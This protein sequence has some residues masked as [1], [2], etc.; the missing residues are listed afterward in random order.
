MSG[1]SNTHDLRENAYVKAQP[2]R[3]RRQIYYYFYRH[4]R[5]W[6]LPGQPLTEELSSSMSAAKLAKETAG[7]TAKNA[8][9]VTVGK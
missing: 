2:D 8:V 4:G 7:G 5:T 3:T 1:T 6:P 9:A